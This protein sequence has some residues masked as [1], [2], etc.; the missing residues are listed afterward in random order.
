M[1]PPV[2]EFAVLR[3]KPDRPVTDSEL[4]ATLRR[5]SAEQ[6]AWSSF[7]L[8]WFTYTTHDGPAPETFNC[9]LSQWASVPAHKAWI[10]SAQNQAL[11]ALLA[12]TIEIASFCHV[13]L[14]P[15]S[16]EID[17][18]LG[19]DKLRWKKLGEEVSEKGDA[20]GWAVDTP[21][22]TFCVFEIVGSDVESRNGDGWTTMSRLD[23]SN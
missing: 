17:K 21:E 23:L 4:H 16:G 5:V 13:A 19:A 22:P 7:P 3:L 14:E 6:S 11:L 9:I 1:L 10:D 2:T 12:P 8:Y 15:K 18:V 20:S